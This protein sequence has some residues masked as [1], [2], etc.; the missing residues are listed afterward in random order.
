[1]W[2]VL[3]ALAVL[4][5]A[6]GG[7]PHLAVLALL[8]AVLGVTALCLAEP[9]VRFEVTLGGLDFDA[10]ER[11]YVP[12]AD[13]EGLTAPHGTEGDEFP[14][15]LYH[16]GGVVRIPAQLNGSSW[17][18]YKFL[19][20]HLL[21]VPA[22]PGAVPRALERFVENELAL[23]GPDKVFA[24]RARRH[25]PL[26]TYG[27][28]VWWS[29]AAAAAGAAWVS[30]A[31]VLGAVLPPAKGRDG[32]DQVA[33]WFVLGTMLV[34][35]G[36]LAASLYSRAGRSRRVR[37]WRGSCL[38]VSPGGIA[39]V[40]GP[41]TGKMRWDE[42]RAVEYPARPRLGL[43]VAGGVVRGVGLMVE[44][45]YLVVADYYDRPLALIYKNLRAYWGG[46]DAN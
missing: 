42:L 39:L 1:V 43:A 12:F 22:T 11:V 41:L 21:P 10:P 23:F 46:R 19:L 16:P 45:V 30:A 15:E 20:S 33:G 25:P 29:A 18:L 31:A 24:Y 14:I 44:G 3:A 38:V 32:W 35:G 8:P 17:S 9:A 28:Q 36:A 40:Q 4:G 37:D 27:R 13:V 26:P 34:L 2:L 7:N 6:A 5:A